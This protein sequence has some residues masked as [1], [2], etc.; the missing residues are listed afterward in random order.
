VVES[1]VVKKFTFTSPDEFLEYLLGDKSN[2][3]VVS[4]EYM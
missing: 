1:V 2:I 3:S 4:V